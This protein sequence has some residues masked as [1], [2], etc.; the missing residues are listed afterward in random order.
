MALP[1]HLPFSPME[2]LRSMK[3]RP[4]RNGATSRNGT[5]FVAWL[6]A[7]AKKFSCSRNPVADDPLFSGIGRGAGCAQTR[8]IRSRRRDRRSCR[9]RLFLRRA[10]AAHP[11]CGSRIRKLSVETP[12]LL[13]AFDLFVGAD[14]RLL[15]ESRSMHAGRCWKRFTGNTAV[16]R[17]RCGC[18]LR[19]PSSAKPKRG[20]GAAARRSTASSPS[21][22]ISPI[23]RAI[24]PAC[25]RSR[26]TAAPTAWSAA[27]AITKAPPSSAHSYLGLYDKR[28]LLNH[29]GFTSTIKRQDKPA[30]T[31]KL[32]PL[33]G[34]PGFTGNAPGGPSRWST[35]RSGEWCR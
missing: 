1:L 31:K 13:I 21:G 26:I 20:C 23:A 19:A 27:S 18:R 6:L 22:A 32:K 7:T 30:L 25:R 5:A 10:F 14:G 2:A 11:S 29:V 35:K 34:P 9:R 15:T 24:A 8:E 3:S 28:G 17:N 4:A 12:A 33:I 16:R